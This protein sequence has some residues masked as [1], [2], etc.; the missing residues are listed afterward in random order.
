LRDTNIACVS[1]SGVRITTLQ[2][3]GIEGDDLADHTL[4]GAAVEAV[5]VAVV[6]LLDAVLE[7]PVAARR[8]RAR[9]QAR[10]AVDVVGVVAL[11]LALPHDTVATQRRHARGQALVLV[12][13]VAVVAHLDAVLDDAVAAGRDRAQVGALVAGHGVGVVALFLALHDAVAAALGDADGRAAV[14][15]EH[16]AVV[17]VLD[18]DL[19]DAVAAHGRRAVALALVVVEPV[20]V[21]ALLVTLDDAVAAHRLGPGLARVGVELRRIA[22]VGVELRRVARLTRLAAVVGLA[23]RRA[24]RRRATRLADLLGATTI[25]GAAD[26]EHGCAEQQGRS[27]V[28]HGASVRPAPWPVKRRR[29]RARRATHDRGRRARRCLAC[30]TRG[31]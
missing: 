14:T 17:A 25:V 3:L 19:N 12:E 24:A 6:A 18:A 10:V 11:L 29:L 26:H 15:V 1:A 23:G 21:V 20:A 30:P 31:A 13:Q 9:A 2:D 28:M 22:G 27:D 4:V 8:E 16:V 7:D 5:A